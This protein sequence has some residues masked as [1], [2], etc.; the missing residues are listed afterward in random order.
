MLVP[1]TSGS[2]DVI[3]QLG[4]GSNSYLGGRK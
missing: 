3:V 2:T 4:V 1:T